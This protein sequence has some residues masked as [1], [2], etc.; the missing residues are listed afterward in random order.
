VLG[1]PNPDLL[2]LQAENQ[3]LRDEVTWLRSL[4]R[5]LVAGRSGDPSK[6]PSPSTLPSSETGTVSKPRVR[7]A[8]DVVIL[9][10][11]TRLQHQ[12]QETLRALP[13][14]VLHPAPLAPE[15]L[16]SSGKGVTGGFSSI[17]ESSKPTGDSSPISG[18]STGSPT[19]SEPS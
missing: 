10:R 17:V 3:T 8:E 2:T 9:D 14:H 11:E 18:P 5:S 15:T 13:P 19:I 1:W 4:V 12:V 7:T 6:G 16:A